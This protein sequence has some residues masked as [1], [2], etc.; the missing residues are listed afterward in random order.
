MSERKSTVMLWLAGTAAGGFLLA[1]GL[2]LVG[3]AY[4]GWH[5]DLVKLGSL[6]FNF[7]FFLVMTAVF[8]RARLGRRGVLPRPSQS[9]NEHSVP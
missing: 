1:F 5:F 9:R 2:T 6:G 7:G 8:M 3:V 4:A